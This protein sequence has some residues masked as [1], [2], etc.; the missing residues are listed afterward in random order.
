[1]NKIKVLHYLTSETY[2]LLIDL[3]HKAK[4]EGNK[5]ESQSSVIEKALILFNAKKKQQTE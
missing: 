4:S 2:Q 5:Q 1:M 3:V